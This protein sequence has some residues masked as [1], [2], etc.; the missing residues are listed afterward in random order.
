VAT[1]DLGD[2]T[3][4]GFK[5]RMSER[6]GREELVIRY[7]K[8][9]GK[10]YVDKNKTGSGSYL[11]VYEPDMVTLDGNRITIRILLDQICYDVYGND[12]EVAVAGLLYSAFESDGMEFFTNGTARIESLTVYNMDESKNTSS[13][14]R[15]EETD[16]AEQTTDAPA[17]P[18]DTAE[19][20]TDVPAETE[21]PR[22]GCASALSGVSVMAVVGA[23]SLALGKKKDAEE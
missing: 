23:V 21:A 3:E 2:A 6:K 16:T 13:D 20:P 9:A 15:P 14:P 18:A 10:L 5:V 7:D 19:L 22:S 11:G 8:T 4:V 1:I 12:G 17:A